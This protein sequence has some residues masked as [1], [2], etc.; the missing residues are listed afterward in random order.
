M[1]TGATFAVDLDCEDEQWDAQVHV[2]GGT[3]D[4]FDG[5][6]F[7]EVTNMCMPDVFLGGFSTV[8]GRQYFVTVEGL[9]EEISGS[10]GGEESG[11]FTLN[12]FEV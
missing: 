8:P 10:S 2:F 4:V 9:S 5:E 11:P 1:G 7:H 6:T 3:C 12:L